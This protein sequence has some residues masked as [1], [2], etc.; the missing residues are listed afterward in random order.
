M[1]QKMIWIMRRRNP[2]RSP[3]RCGRNRHGSPFRHSLKK[4]V[5]IL[6]S[7]KNVEIYWIIAELRCF[8][9][10]IM[11]NYSISLHRWC[12]ISRKKWRILEFHVFFR[13]CKTTTGFI[14]RIYS[15]ERSKNCWR[16]TTNRTPRWSPTHWWTKGSATKIHFKIR[17]NLFV[18]TNSL[19][20][21]WCPMSND[22][23]WSSFEKFNLLLT[24]IRGH[25]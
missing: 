16:F 15:N 24:L 18:K 14:W 6:F 21:R 22:A 13:S 17:T 23:K 1:N 19:G 2:K 10:K 8:H 25:Y 5:K 9:I 3:P 11:R 7:R 20:K 4:K 12:M